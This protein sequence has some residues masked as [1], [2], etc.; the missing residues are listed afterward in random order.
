MRGGGL[1]TVAALAV[2]VVYVGTIGNGVRALRNGCFA[3][4]PGLSQFDSNAHF[5]WLP[6]ALRLLLLQKNKGRKS[7]RA[8]GLDRAP[9]QATFPSTGAVEYDST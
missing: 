9:A 3:P 1:T 2:I 8:V 6:T 7:R 5:K 4:Y